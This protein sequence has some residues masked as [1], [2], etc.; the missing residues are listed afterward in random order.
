MRFFVAPTYLDFENIFWR[1]DTAFSLWAVIIANIWL[2][3]AF[4]MILLS[5]GAT[6]ARV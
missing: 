4:N 2:G 6:E 1:S 3:T 5:V